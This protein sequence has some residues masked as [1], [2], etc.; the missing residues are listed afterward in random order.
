MKCYNSEMIPKVIHYCWFGNKPKPEIVLH[1]IESWKKFCP[2]YLVKE[3][4]ED[5][6]N[7]AAH[8]FSRLMYANKQWA[9]VADYARLEI[10][11][12]E[13]GIYLDTDMLLVQPLDELL[14]TELLLGE[15]NDGVISAGMIGATAQHPFII[16]CMRYYDKH[17][18]ERI[19]IPR[20]LTNIFNKSTN[21]DDATVLPS[22][23]FYPFGPEDI[24]N[25]HGQRLTLSTYGI[26]LWNY[27]WGHP[28]NKFLKRIGVYSFARKTTEALKI[29]SA[30]KKIIGIV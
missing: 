30:L 18:K 13:G 25:Y 3:W 26:H 19:T 4:N 11:Y 27:S 21:V 16:E 22:I 5:N 23:A 7:I 28:L 24:K 29:K 20:V 9:F 12:K 8:P 14:D 2:D 15:E 17:V 6:V 1:C 10:L